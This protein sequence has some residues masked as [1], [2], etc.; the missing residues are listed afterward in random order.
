MYI[1]LKKCTLMDMGI[2]VSSELYLSYTALE[3][4]LFSSAIAIPGIPT[5]GDNF[6]MTCISTGPERLVDTPQLDWEVEINGMS[7]ILVTEAEADIGL[8]IIGDIVI[9]GSANFSRTL[10]FTKIRTSQARQY[11]CQVFVSGIISQSAFGI[12]AVRSMS[13]LL[14]SSNKCKLFPFVFFFSSSTS[15]HC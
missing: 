5:A 13:Q 12:L 6:T 8:V 14:L 3:D 4:E 1:F 10:S 2:H 9:T 15:C 7:P 11:A